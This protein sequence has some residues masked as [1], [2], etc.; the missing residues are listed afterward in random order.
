MSE[1]VTVGFAGAGAIARCHAFALQALPFYYEG[2]PR[3]VKSLV[4]SA[5]PERAQQFAREAGFA[6]A[7][8]EAAFWSSPELDTVF[9]LGPNRLHFEHARRALAL[10][11][12]RRIYLEKPICV[13]EDEARQMAEWPRLH[14]EVRIQAGFQLMY[15][16]GTRHALEQWRTGA[17]GRPLH[18]KLSLLH[19]GY[20]DDAYRATRASRLAPLPEGGALVDLGSH[21]LSL[22]LAF[23]GD[24]ISV[25]S[26]HALQPFPEVDPRSDMHTHVVLRDDASG[27]TGTITAS[28][29]ASGHEETFE[30]EFSGTGGAVRVSSARP[31]TAE[32]CTAANRQD[33]KSV[34]TGSDYMPDSR[35]PARAVA[36]GW[37]RPL[38]HAHFLF[39]AEGPRD[40]FVPDLTHGLRVQELIHEIALKLAD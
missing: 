18:F 13:T 29:I 15:G 1:P 2:V 25:Q 20:I 7:V 12:I 26:A 36:G 8:D 9:V 19:S 37:L 30:L 24:G 33:W 35:F 17:F 4:T 32:I 38:I 23:L 14:P 27:A 40:T 10:P 16:S 34:R 31:D 39:L 3:V 5:R 22:V 11:R 6:A 28:R 21:L